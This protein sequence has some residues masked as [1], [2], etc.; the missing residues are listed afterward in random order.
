MIVE[1]IYVGAISENWLVLPLIASILRLAQG[2]IHL[3]TRATTLLETAQ[4]LRV[5]LV[6][7]GA[8]CILDKLCYYANEII[9]KI[10]GKH[11]TTKG[12]TYLGGG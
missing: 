10:V 2:K 8:I 3:I 6:M 9:V 1:S 7:R 11:G 4:L 12:V 5:H